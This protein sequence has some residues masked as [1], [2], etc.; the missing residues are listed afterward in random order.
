MN[1]WTTLITDAVAISVFAFLA[2]VAHRDAAPLNVGNWF[3]TV[4]PFL[5][6]VLA[7]YA[8]VIVPTRVNAAKIWPPGV[9]IWVLT[10]AIGLTI[11]SFRHGTA[12]HWSFIIVASSTSGIL[13]LGW[14][15]VFRLL[16]K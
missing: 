7:A 13:L 5:I 15:L 2:R 12:P 3:S 6:G 14:R 1:R 4:W 16:K 11:W 10:V 9:S 8:I